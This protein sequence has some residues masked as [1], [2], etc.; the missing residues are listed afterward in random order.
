M[1]GGAATFGASAKPL[2]TPAPANN[3]GGGGGGFSFG[4]TPS[5]PAANQNASGGGGF[6][7]GA[8]ATPSGSRC[9]LQAC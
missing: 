5:K 8:T 3:N 1:F 2:A 6:P 9:Y 4:A 7:F